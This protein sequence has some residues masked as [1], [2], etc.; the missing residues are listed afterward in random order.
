MAP[1]LAGLARGDEQL[2]N[3]S[4]HHSPSEKRTAPVLRG[5]LS[6]V[7]TTLLAVGLA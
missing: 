7:L 4:F 3:Y 1:A 2:A 5:N 6:T